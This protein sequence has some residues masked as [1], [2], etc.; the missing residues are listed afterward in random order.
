MKAQL[1]LSWGDDLLLANCSCKTSLN[2]PIH[3]GK[4]ILSMEIDWLQ[5]N[6]SDKH[7]TS[8]SDA[9]SL[10]WMHFGPVEEELIMMHSIAVTMHL[11]ASLAYPPRFGVKQ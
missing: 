2:V 1:C 10:L 5:S 4:H 6:V 8:T 3:T 9:P 11:R 7:G